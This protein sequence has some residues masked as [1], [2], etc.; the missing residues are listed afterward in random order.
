[1]G[2]LKKIAELRKDEAVITGGK[3]ANLGELTQNGFR[4]PQGFNVTGP[5]LDHVISANGLMG[6]IMRIIGTM[7]F[8]NYQDIEA[9]R[10]KSEP[11]RA[12]EDSTGLL[13]EIKGA[14]HRCRTKGGR[15]FVAVRFSV[16]VKDSE[17]QLSR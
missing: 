9:N 13:D 7:D 12:G 1:M 17:S 15:P 10:S 11:D 8:E 16:S 3:A 2:Y 4:V 6:P 5:A 14:I